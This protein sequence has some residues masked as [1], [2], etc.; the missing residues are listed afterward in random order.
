ME[1]I[2]NAGRIRTVRLPSNASSSFAPS[3]RF[4]LGTQGVC[5]AALASLHSVAATRRY[6]SFK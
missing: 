4:L 2:V 3:E 5:A 6:S 1:R